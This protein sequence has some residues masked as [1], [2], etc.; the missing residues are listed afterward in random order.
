MIAAAHIICGLERN[1][2][3]GHFARMLAESEKVHLERFGNGPEAHA[4]SGEVGLASGVS[5]F[6]DE[7]PNAVR[8]VV[9][10]IPIQV[11]TTESVVARPTG[12]EEGENGNAIQSAVLHEGNLSDAVLEAAQDKVPGANRRRLGSDLEGGRKK[13]EAANCNA[14]KRFGR[15]FSHKLGECNL[16]VTRK[17]ANSRLSQNLLTIITDN[18]LIPDNLGV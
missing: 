15:E 13:E 7:A 3:E 16:L 8:P 10:P 1:P 6:I 2:F 12:P 11:R 9:G 4:V 5:H 18:R 17:Q 14:P